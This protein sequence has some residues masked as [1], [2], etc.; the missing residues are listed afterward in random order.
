MIPASGCQRP[1]LHAL[2][3]CPNSCRGACRYGRVRTVSTRRDRRGD[4]RWLE[5]SQGPGAKVLYPETAPILKKQGWEALRK[6][7]VERDDELAGDTD[8]PRI[9]RAAHIAWRFRAQTAF[10]LKL[11]LGSSILAI[12]LCFAA[13]PFTPRIV[14]S[15][16]A[17]G[18]I[19]TLAV[20]LGIASLVLY[21]RLI[22]TILGRIDEA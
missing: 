20:G 5:C 21:W 11:S 7:L 9:F 6:L 10:W 19:L 22:W 18:A 13:L 12:A 15:P 8:A 1:L 3:D 4:R 17:T 16:L 2:H 14:C